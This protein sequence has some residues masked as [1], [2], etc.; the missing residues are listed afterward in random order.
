MAHGADAD[1]GDNGE[2]AYTLKLF[3]VK[4]TQRFTIRTL[5]HRIDGLFTHYVKPKGS[6]GS[7]AWCAGEGQGCENHKLP[8]LWKGYAAIEVW[9]SHSGLWFPTV[10]EITE[11]LELDFRGV[12]KRGQQWVVSRGPVVKDKN[13]PVVA[14]LLGND[15]DENLPRAFDY[16][17]V[18]QTVY[19]APSIQLGCANPLPARVVLK[20]ST[21]APPIGTIFKDVPKQSESDQKTFRELLQAYKMTNAEKVKKS[22]QEQE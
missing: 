10:F 13:P 12:W 20:A 15:P 4:A 21:A 5:S 2:V 11:H 17:P 16:L 19:H 8:R 7:S 3:R 18:L 1:H 22:Q 14:G 9:D 6:A